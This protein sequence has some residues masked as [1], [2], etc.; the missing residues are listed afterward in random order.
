MKKAHGLVGRKQPKS[1]IEKRVKAIRERTKK[2]IDEGTK[3]R[4]KRGFGSGYVGVRV[5]EHPYASKCGYVM[6]HRLVMEFFLG[7][8]LEPHEQVHHINGRKTD[9]RIWN[10][11][12]MT[13]AEHTRMHVRE[14]IENGAFHNYKDVSEKS[15]KEA[16]KLSGTVGEIAERLNIDKSTFYRKLDQLSLRDWYTHWRKHGNDSLFNRNYGN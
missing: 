6:E 16:V 7:R 11:E 14:R 9:N 10:L 13:A 1:T 4:V 5:P 15:I 3:G 2:G 8:Y 12:L